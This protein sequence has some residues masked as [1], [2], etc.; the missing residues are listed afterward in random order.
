MDYNCFFP[1]DLHSVLFDVV[2]VKWKRFNGILRM[3]RKFDISYCNC[4]L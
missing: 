1:V 2:T 3:V 4:K